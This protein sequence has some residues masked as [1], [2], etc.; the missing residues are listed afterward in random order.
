[1][2]YYYFILFY[3]FAS[4]LITNA[5]EKALAKV[6]YSFY[7]INDSNHKDQPLRDKVVTY[8]SKNSSYYTTYSDVIIQKDIAAQKA[9]ADFT[10][11]IVLKF[12]TTAIKEFYLI[13]KESKEMDKVEAISSSFDAFTYKVPLE[14]QNWEILEETK[15]IGGYTCQKAITLFKGRT[16]EAWFTTELPFPFGPWKLHSLPGLILEAYDDK[17]EVKFEYNGFEK[18]D[19]D[20]RVEIPFYVIK[21]NPSEIEKIRKAFNE[22]QGTYFQS[23]QNSGRMNIGNEFLGIDYSLH[24][25]DLSNEDDYKP[26]FKTNNPIELTER[27]NLQ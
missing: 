24:R 13:N 21:S 7:H 16:Y 17:R 23:L 3:F 20:S 15:E 25:F 4:V 8:L 9:L 26:S 2:R 1:M 19:D 11:H 12:T 6:H 10:G 5:Q 14:E 22:D 27:K 18:L